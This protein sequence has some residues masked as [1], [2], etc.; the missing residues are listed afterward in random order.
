MANKD[1]V[2]NELRAN[3]L[4]ALANVTRVCII[5]NLKDRP[6]NVTE[7]ALIIGESNS[8][9][10]RHLN[11]LKAAGL[12]EDEKKGTTV[13][14]SLASNGIPDILDSVDEVIEMNYKKYQAFFNK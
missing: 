2:R 12:V 10:S 4:K 13:I 9:T 6:Y 3:I 1:R 14:Y 5:E 8:I 11:V 7:L